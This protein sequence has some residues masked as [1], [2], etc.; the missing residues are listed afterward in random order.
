MTMKTTPLSEEE[1]ELVR[2]IRS[3]DPPAT[4]PV[5]RLLTESLRRIARAANQLDALRLEFRAVADL[6]LR[7]EVERGVRVERPR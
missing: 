5:P 1:R 2:F 3:A 4:E 7:D 6:A